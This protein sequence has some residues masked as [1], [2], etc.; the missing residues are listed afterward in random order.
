[1]AGRAEVVPD[2]GPVATR[3][4][5][6]AAGNWDDSIAVKRFEGHGGR[7]I[8]GFGQL[9]GPH[10]V[11]VGDERIT[12]RRGIVIATGS[13]PAIPPIE[14]LAE[15]DYWTTHDLI[16][17]ATLPESLLV[18]GGGAVGCELG[19]VMA[20]FG[21]NVTIV[22]AGERLLPAEEPEAS[23]VL[24]AAFAAEDIHVHTALPA[25][26]VHSRNESIVVTLAGGKEL[27]SER[28]LVATGRRVELSSLDWNP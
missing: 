5:T 1:M 12:A 6:E 8:H 27:A 23:R 7:L 21:V 15:V 4:R 2:W 19:Q 9:C 26:R 16:Q 20:R 28:L 11:A 22:E 24:E 18:L 17:A 10:T 13:K 25:V 14:G 3:V